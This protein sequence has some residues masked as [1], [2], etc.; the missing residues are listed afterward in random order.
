[1]DEFLHPA[2][3]VQAECAS[4]TENNTPPSRSAS[5]FP[6]RRVDSSAPLGDE[7]SDW[8]SEVGGRLRDQMFVQ[9][10]PHLPRPP[11]QRAV[12]PEV[13]TRLFSS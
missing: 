12:G 4:A 9:G 10:H 3:P 2:D 1:M 6:A 13:R 7:S 11:R 8:T 5:R